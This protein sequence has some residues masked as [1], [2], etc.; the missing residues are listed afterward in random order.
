M[1]AEHLGYIAGVITTVSFIPQV[2]RVYKNKSGKDVSL[3]MVMMLSLGTLLWL[4]Y[5]LMVN[6]LP[7]IIANAVT[8][9]LVLVIL[10]L[11]I[12]YW[13]KYPR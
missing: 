2:V 12:Y 10:I 3:I 9:S 4:V 7:I 6:G 11:K 8:F 13:K 5:G 1:N